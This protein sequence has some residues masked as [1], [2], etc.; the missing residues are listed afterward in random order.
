VKLIEYEIFRND[1][2]M[3]IVTTSTLQAI[4]SLNSMFIEAE[5]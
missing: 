5:R 1:I 2:K 3:L 4:T